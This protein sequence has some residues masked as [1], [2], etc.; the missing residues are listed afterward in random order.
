MGRALVQLNPTYQDLAV[1]G[2]VGGFNTESRTATGVQ[3]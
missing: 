1:A 2:G 3:R